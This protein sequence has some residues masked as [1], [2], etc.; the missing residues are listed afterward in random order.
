MST[1]W[2]V[3]DVFRDHYESFVDADTGRPLVF[4]YVGMLGVPLAVGGFIAGRGV[5]LVNLGQLLAGVGVF[6]G[7]LF[8]LLLQI[9]PLSQRLTDDPRLHGQRRLAQLVDE[10]EANA[11][12]AVLVGLAC[13]A[14]LM[15]VSTLISNA[16]ANRW[17]S[18]AVAALLLHLLL[19]AFMVLKRVRFVYGR[20]RT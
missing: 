12:Y 1:K 6:T 7:G 15:S 9:F 8:A 17:W 16:E 14:L 20:M 4:D 13:V 2:S 19:T 11:S 5:E 18:G 3:I 10:L